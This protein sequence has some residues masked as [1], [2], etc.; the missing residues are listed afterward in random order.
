MHKMRNKLIQSSSPKICE[1]RSDTTYHMFPFQR[2]I[3]FDGAFIKPVNLASIMHQK[4][5]FKFSKFN[6]KRRKAVVL[7]HEK[8]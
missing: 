4:C 1:R 8:F 3:R 5:I 2:I 6:L 7:H